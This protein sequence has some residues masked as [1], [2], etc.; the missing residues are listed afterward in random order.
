MSSEIKKEVFFDVETTGLDPFD[1]HVITIQVRADG[2]TTI[3]PV[4]SSSERKVISSFLSFTD[5]IFRREARFIGYNVLK[6]DVPF[7][8]E[9][10]HALGLLTY[11]F[12]ERVNKELSWFDMYQFLGD[13]FGRFRDSKPGLTGR[14]VETM[15]REIPQLYLD[16]KY[17]KIMEYIEDEMEG[18]EAVYQ[19]IKKER[20]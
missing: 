19:A 18:Y 11:E 5:R 12:W 8:T 16:K 4:W 20:L 14:A 10:M 2:R 1:S 17:D 6:F 13:Q 15:N 7:I 9:R 3:W